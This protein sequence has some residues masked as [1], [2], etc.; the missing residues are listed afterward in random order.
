MKTMRGDLKIIKQHYGLRSLNSYTF[1]FMTI[2]T[3]VE[4]SWRA[5]GQF[6]IYRPNRS[7]RLNHRRV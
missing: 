6:K 1:Y 5:K 2:P 3:S 4:P 7:S